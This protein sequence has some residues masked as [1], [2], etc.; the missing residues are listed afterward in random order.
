MVVFGM[1]IGADETLLQNVMFQCGAKKFITTS[2]EII[3]LR[4]SCVHLAGTL[5]GF[6][7]VCLPNVRKLAFNAFGGFW[8]K[9][10]DGP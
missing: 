4:E 9:V 5:S 6:G 1:D 10:L 2:A 7:N 3:E 8:M